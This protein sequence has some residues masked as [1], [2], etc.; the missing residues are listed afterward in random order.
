MPIRRIHG[1]GA[2]L[3]IRERS[4]KRARRAITAALVA[5]LTTSAAITAASAAAAPARPASGSTV[6]GTLQVVTTDYA[7]HIRQGAGRLHTGL[8][9]L[10]L[11]NDGK[12]DHE[13]QLARL[14]PGVSVAE[15]LHVLKTAGE[16]AALALVDFTGGAAPVAPHGT[17]T[18]YQPLIPGNYLLL[19]MVVGPDGIPHLMKGM[20]HPV[21]VTGRPGPVRSPGHVLGTITAHDMTYTLPAVIGGH[22]LYRFRNTDRA[23]VHELAIVRLRPHVSRADVIAWFRHPAG[24]PPF[25]SAGGFGAIPPGANGWLLLNLAPGHYAALCY[26]PDNK[27][28]HLPHAAMGM[29]VTFT[30]H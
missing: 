29:V 24:P 8:I 30:I 1:H 22:G 15:F 25:T 20:Y 26:V 3:A 18:T 23:D 21:T 19:C 10:Q 5:A 27:A 12:M 6:A 13:A 17:Q 14:H 28:P 2:R 9:R 16:G 4:P 7:F 11:A